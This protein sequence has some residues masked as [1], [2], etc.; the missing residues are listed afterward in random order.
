MEKILS[1][2]SNR[3][4]LSWSIP[5]KTSTKTGEPTINMQIK[6][7]CALA[8]WNNFSPINVRDDIVIRS[9]T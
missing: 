4:D 6:W 7:L 8:D 5:G 2:E 9:D 1:F 3:V